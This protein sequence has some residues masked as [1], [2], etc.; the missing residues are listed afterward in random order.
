MEKWQINSI[1]ATVGT[2]LISLF[3][4]WDSMM[5]ALV[6]ICAIDYTTG[7]LAAIYNG[8]LSSKIGY[9]GIIKKICMFAIVAVACIL[10]DPMKTELLREVTILFYIS[11]EAISILENVGKTG[12]KYPKKLKNILKE[13]RDKEHK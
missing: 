7:L 4:G 5:Q 10:D 3:G 9:K 2:C 12:V 8:K 11:N 1:I 13:L 6:I